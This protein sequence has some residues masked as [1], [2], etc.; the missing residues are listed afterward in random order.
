MQLIINLPKLKQYATQYL[1]LTGEI[2]ALRVTELTGG[3]L[4]LGLYR[5]DLALETA[6]GFREVSFIQWSPI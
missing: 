5:H 2:H 6:K 3:C 1:G 4:A